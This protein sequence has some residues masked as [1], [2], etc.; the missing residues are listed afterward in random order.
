M[1]PSP[2]PAPINPGELIRWFEVPSCPGV[3]ALGSFARQVTF[4]SQQIR[5]FN[6]I[7]ALCSTNRL[8]EGSRVAVVG[9]GLGGITATVAALVRGCAVDLYE[10]ASQ[11][12][13][14]QRGNDLRFIHP[15]IL[16]WPEDGSQATRTDLP[17]LNWT[18]SNVRGVIKQIDL[19]WKRYRGNSRLRRFFNYQVGRLHVVS[20]ANSLQQPCLTANRVIDG[21]AAGEDG[22]DMQQRGYM[23]AAY[24]CVILAVGF[25]E[26]RSML[27]VPFLSYWE[28]DSLHQETGRERSILV[29]GCGDG[30]LIDA[31]RLRLRNFDHA[32]FIRQFQ[33]AGTAAT[34]RNALKQV[35]NQLRGYAAEPDISLRFQLAYD[36][37]AV[38]P[39]M[40]AYFRNGKRT[41]TAV[42]LNSPAP[43]PLSF[44]ASVLNRYATYLAIRLSD[45][46]YLSGRVAAQR[47]E[48]GKYHITLQR[49]ENEPYETRAFD[50][51]IVRH[52]P[53]S[54]LRR[55]VP[56]SAVKKLQEW[57][58]GKD[59]ITARPHWC[60]EGGGYVH[61]FF[62]F[63]SQTEPPA[64]DVVDLAL[65]TFEA[66][67]RELKD[68]TV[69]SMGVG[70]YEGKA[71]FV[72]TLKPGVV[73]PQS[74]RYADVLVQYVAAPGVPAPAP[75]PAG[76]LL[77]VGSGIYNFD[78]QQRLAAAIA[79]SQG[80]AHP[81]YTEPGSEPWR[82]YPTGAGSLG[83][84]AKDR[85]GAVYLISTAYVLSPENAGIPGDRIFLE[86]ES[87]GD[88]APVATLAV[89]HPG[90]QTR[91]V[92]VAA[93]LLEPGAHPDYERFS[94]RWW[95]RALGRAT[96]GDS[97][98]KVGRTSGLTV[99][100]VT[101]IDVDVTIV[102]GAAERVQL[103]HCTRIVGM[104]DRDFSMPG[105][106]GAL[107]VNE[108]GKAF[109]LLTAASS[110]SAGSPGITIASSLEAALRVLEME[111]VTAESS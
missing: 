82:S 43:G 44:R 12:C 108:D 51:V 35:D 31:L 111:L 105:D 18:A 63:E 98:A 71:G 79:H 30:G 42:T 33:G 97:V 16:R 84:F 93:A 34:L 24:D 23:E 65:A 96:P 72:L 39:A 17:Y 60:A 76:R 54:A 59:D 87:P 90:S 67:Y 13:P 106:S 15:N 74:V 48:S 103:Q 78:A 81:L 77:P 14:I 22:S 49:D 83:C 89:F 75:A 50:L 56:A 46:H 19:Q 8:G 85:Q 27:G 5:A 55:L 109:G 104:M 95:P 57:W 53:E 47:V 80:H 86:G 92:D 40:E 2:T 6:L 25:G 94:E 69:S 28:N 36:A 32:E 64:D 3:F 4:A 91:D 100:M 68:E 41:D 70:T 62:G 37:I 1:T 29:S 21:S 9:A 45:L 66:A 110:R 88:H 102:M 10:Q 61:Q 58:D 26:E 107:I 73:P 38:P 7:W 20:G 101:D 52:G 99:G 11:T